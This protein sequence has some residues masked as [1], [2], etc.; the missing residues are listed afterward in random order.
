MP[1]LIRRSTA[2]ST[3]SSYVPSMWLYEM[4]SPTASLSPAMGPALIAT[5]WPSIRIAPENVRRATFSRKRLEWI[6]LRIDSGELFLIYSGE[7]FN[8]ADLR[9]ELGRAGPR[10]P[11]RS[12]TEMVRHAYEE[13]GAA[14]VERFRGMFSFGLWDARRRRLFCARDRLGIKPFYY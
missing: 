3:S 4:C 9:P 2:S 13:F 1:G 14:C 7:V 12:D 5:V 6:R 8:H 11:S 10:Y